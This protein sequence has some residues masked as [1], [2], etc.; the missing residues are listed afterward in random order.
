P[1][2]FVVWTAKSRQ[3]GWFSE[4]SCRHC[5]SKRDGALGSGTACDVH[6]TVMPARLAASRCMGTQ[7]IRCAFGNCG[8]VIM[9][10]SAASNSHPL[11]WPTAAKPQVPETCSQ[12]TTFCDELLWISREAP[13][14]NRIASRT[15]LE[16]T[17]PL[18]V[19][20]T[21]GVLAAAGAASVSTSATTVAVSVR[22][23]NRIGPPWFEANAEAYHSEGSALKSES[24]PAPRHRQI[25]SRSAGAQNALMESEPQARRVRS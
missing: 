4:V 21:S 7:T 20:S 23:R 12:N 13:T 19:N 17:K 3:R 2:T 25:S 10:V 18:S 14:F 15:T 1:S 11:S 16:G 9:V 22:R 5:T 24:Y 6:R 8:V